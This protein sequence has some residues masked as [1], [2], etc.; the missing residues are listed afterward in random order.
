M[1]IYQ[2]PEPSLVLSRLCQDVVHVSLEAIQGFTEKHF[3]GYRAIRPVHIRLSEAV[4]TLATD[5]GTVILVAAAAEPF[6]ACE[7]GV[8]G[9]AECKAYIRP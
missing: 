2:R 8:I 3:E 5:P 6:A 1:I 4:I 7:P 9:G